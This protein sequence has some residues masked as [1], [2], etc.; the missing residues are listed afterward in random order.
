MSQH[1]EHTKNFKHTGWV[2]VVMNIGR[3]K[4]GGLGHTEPSFAG[5]QEES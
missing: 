5:G 2:A 4:Q 3:R 1:Q